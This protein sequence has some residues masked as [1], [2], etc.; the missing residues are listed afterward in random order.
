MEDHSWTAEMATFVGAGT[1]ATVLLLALVERLRRTFATRQDLNGV[2]EKLTAFQTLYV[3]VRES[4]DAARDRIAAAEAEQH[5]RW[6]QINQQVIRPLQRVTDKLEGVLE[7][8]AAQGA[9]LEHIRERLDRADAHRDIHAGEGPRG[10]H[11]RRRR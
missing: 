8:Q 10:P 1:F 3:Q 7:V 6:E 5:H 2:G 11:A 9:A 4:V